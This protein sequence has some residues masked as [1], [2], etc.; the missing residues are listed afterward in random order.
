MI[1]IKHFCDYCK[2]EIKEM[3]KFSLISSQGHPSLS[4]GHS[5]SYT[6]FLCEEIC[7]IRTIQNIVHDRKEG[8]DLSVQFST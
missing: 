3:R 8:S 2:Q 7:L 1:I 5:N 6:Y 4:A